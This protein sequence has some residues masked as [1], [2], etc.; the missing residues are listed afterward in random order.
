MN[1]PD[2]GEPLTFDLGGF[3][4]LNNYGMDRHEIW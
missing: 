3:E 1:P 2:F 4:C